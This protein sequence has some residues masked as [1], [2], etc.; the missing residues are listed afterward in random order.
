MCIGELKIR[1]MEVV[2]GFWLVGF[3]TLGKVFLVFS[4]LDYYV[5]DIY[6]VK[7]KVRGVVKKER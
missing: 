5:N 7:E 2:W 1:L 4:D 3:Y 6:K